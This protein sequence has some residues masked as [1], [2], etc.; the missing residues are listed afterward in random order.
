MLGRTLLSAE[1][2]T[3]TAMPTTVNPDDVPDC[4]QMSGLLDAKR[5]YLL[6]TFRVRFRQV[7]FHR[8]QRLQDRRWIDKLR[9]GMEEEVDREQYPVQ[10]ILRNDKTWE[11]RGGN[12]LVADGSEFLP[13]GIVVIV[14]DGQHRVEAWK[15]SAKSEQDKW[16]YTTLYKRGKYLLGAYGIS[17]ETFPALE[18]ERPGEF[19]SMMHIGN[20]SESRKP[21][22]DP[23]RFLLVHR[24]RCLLQEKKIDADTYQVHA[25]RIMG[26]SGSTARSAIPSLV[27]SFSVST[28]IADLVEYPE[29]RPTFSASGWKKLTEGRL[30]PV[31]PDNWCH[32]GTPEIKSP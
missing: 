23:D 19:Y 21:H 16:W 20:E 8:H 9:Q 4:R 10:A 15:E 7:E 25:K 18:T 26:P 30:Y 17:L 1:R 27:R 14:Y 12:L 22:G 13:D 2:S 29:V 31:S 24:L 28:A 32:E 11:D 3:L 6:G 5:M